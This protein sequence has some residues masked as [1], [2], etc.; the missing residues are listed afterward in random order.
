MNKTK[1]SR[2][3]RRLSTLKGRFL[4]LADELVRSTSSAEKV[5]TEVYQRRK[6][7]IGA[8][9]EQF[10]SG[11]GSSNS[12]DLQAY[13]DTVDKLAI[14][15]GFKGAIFVDIGCGDFRV[16]SQLL[17]SAGSYVGVDVVRPLIERNQR[18]F[19]G[20]NVRFLYADA[21]R[22]P[23]PQGDVC[24]LRQVLQHLSNKQITAILNKLSQYQ[25]V[26]V[27]EHIP[28]SSHLARPN[29]DKLHG[30][31]VRV[32]RGS[33]VFLE[34]PPFGIPREKLSTVLE[35]PGTDLGPGIHPGVI[36]TSLYQPKKPVL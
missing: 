19:A 33:G 30:A 23:L 20:A 26:I 16:G 34:Q 11:L 4:E 32:Y 35:V 8:T 17:K 25:W 9:S 7:G 2:L 5:F 10:D 15:H 3:H 27:T 31:D 14:E 36:R 13:I 12:P 18:L 21:T 24:V 22:D 1:R 6:W 28:D 29:L